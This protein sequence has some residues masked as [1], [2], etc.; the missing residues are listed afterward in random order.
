MSAL[1]SR[2]TWVFIEPCRAARRASSTATLLSS[3]DDSSVDCRDLRVPVEPISPPSEGS[4]DHCH[5]GMARK[6]GKRRTSVDV[7]RFRDLLTQADAALDR[8]PMTRGFRGGSVSRRPAVAPRGIAYTGSV[9]RREAFRVRCLR[10][11]SRRVPQPQ[12]PAH[13]RKETGWVHHSSA[14]QARGNRVQRI[15]CAAPRANCSR[16]GRAFH[17]CCSV[18]S[19]RTSRRARRSCASLPVPDATWPVSAAH[20]YGNSCT[21]PRLS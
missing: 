19:P 8:E 14:E 21:I 15:L 2:S 13:E 18:G 17:W 1:T 9:C 10:G 16:M 12:E 6:D 7:P 4:P 3:I 20:R 11:H 5:A